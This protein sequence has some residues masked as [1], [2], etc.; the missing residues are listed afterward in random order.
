MQVVEHGCR[1]SR[2]VIVAMGAMALLHEAASAADKAPNNNAAPTPTA[3]LIPDALRQLTD[4][5][6]WRSKLEQAGLQFAFTYYGD[7]FG[8]PRGGVSQGSGYDGRFG[9]IIDTDMEKL[10]GWSGASLH[11]SIHQIH[12]SQFSTTRLQNFALVSG[13]EAP[14]STRLFNL[15]M[16]QK[17]GSDVN[18]R[19][20]QFSAAQEFLV[21]Q[22]AALFVNATFGWPVLPAQD[23][24]SGGPSYPEATPGVRVTFTPTDQLTL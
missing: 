7:S 6:G 19:L 5:S 14:P 23:L 9:I 17:I 1:R 11:A 10:A 3:Q 24:P 13:I 2:R 16:E 20:G 4:P 12:G 22:T 21:S 18:V 15:W 8:N